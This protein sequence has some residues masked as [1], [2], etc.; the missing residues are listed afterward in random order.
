MRRFTRGNAIVAA[1]TLVWAGAA[2]PAHA[3]PSAPAP[4]PTGATSGAGYVQPDVPRALD[5]GLL[6]ATGDTRFRRAKARLATPATD[7]AGRTFVYVEGKSF[8]AAKAAVTAVNGKVL[9]SNGKRV[10]AAVPGSALVRL[11]RRPGVAQ[12]RQPDK[13]F[14]LAVTS[15]GV[16]ASGAGAWVRAGDGGAGVKIGVIDVGFD[17][18]TDAQTAGEVPNDAALHSVDCP[19]ENASPHGTAVAEVVHDMAPGASLYLACAPDSMTFASA[20]GW[21][22]QQGVQII[23]A[24]I[25]FPN[26]GRGDGSGPAGSPAAVVQQSR[27]AGVLWVAAAGNQAQLHWTGTAADA[28]A[29]GYVE[30]NGTAESNGFT[31]PAGGTATVSLKWDGWPTT[32]KDLDLVVMSNNRQPTGPGDAAIVAQSTNAQADAAQPLAPTEQVTIDNKSGGAQTYWIYTAARASYPDTRADLYVMGDATSLSYPVAAGSVLEPASS[33]YAM[34]VGASL[35]GSGRVDDYS[36]QGPTVDGRT[37]PDIVGQSGVSSMTFGPAPTFA[38]TSVGAAHVTGAAALLKG[39]N[40]QLDPG[41]IQALLEERTKPAK[42]DNQWGHGLL[43]M[44]APGAAQA[45]ATSGYTPLQLPRRLLDT[46]TTLGGHNTPLAAGEVFTLPVAD[47][48][49]D[50]TAVAVNVTGSSANRTHIDL[51][52]D[53]DSYSGVSTVELAANETRTA[54]AIVPLSVARTIAIRNDAGAANAN[55]DLLGYFS[56]ASSGTYTPKDAPQRILDTRGTVGGHNAAFGAGEQFTLPVRGVAGVPETATAVLVNITVTEASAATNLS[57]YPQ[58]QPGQ[59]GTLETD[60]NRVRSNLA[61]TGIGDDGG[62]RIRNQS[63]T[64]QVSVDLVGWFAAGSGARYVPLRF[65]TKILDTRTGTGGQLGPVAQGGTASV[66]VSDVAGVPHSVT[67]PVLAVTGQSD[68]ATSLSLGPAERGWSGLA[69]IAGIDSG[70]TVAGASVP[71]SGG[72]GKVKIRN[73]AGGTQVVVAVTGYF[74]GGPALQAQTGSCAIDAEAGFT[75]MYDGRSPQS[76]QWRLVGAGTVTDANCETS[77]TTTG[78]LRWYPTEHLPAQYTLRLD[79]KATSNTADSGVLLGFANPADDPKAP[80]TTGVE[81]QISPGGAATLA[82]GAI[83]SLK[84]P[85]AQAAKAPGTWNSYEIQ[86]SGKRITVLLNDTVVNDYVVPNTRLLDPGFIG[87]QSNPDGADVTY[88]NIRVRVDAPAARYGPIVGYEGMCVDVVGAQKVQGTQ[89]QTATCTGGD[90]QQF[91]LPGDGTLRI[92]GMC[93]DMNG[94]ARSS[95]TQY[96]V[97][98]TC[99]GTSNQQ[100]VLQPNGTLY[101]PRLNTCLDVPGTTPLYTGPCHG[102]ANQ[103]WAVPAAQARFGPVIGYQGMCVDVVDQSTAKGAQLQTAAC[104]KLG[105][106]QVTMPGDGTLRIYGMCVDMNG[107]ARS[108]TTQ[109]VVLWTCNGT[110]NQ[111]YSLRSNGTLYAPHL[112][113]CLDT[114]GTTPLY[115]GPCHGLANQQWAVPALAPDGTVVAA[116]AARLVASWSAD[117]N[118]G[119]TLADATGNGRPATLKGGYTWTTGHSGS[120]V[121]FDG[122]TGEANAAPS[123]LQTDRSY[124]VAAWVKVT[125]PT[126]FPNAVGEDDAQRSAFFL[127]ASGDPVQWEFVVSTNPATSDHIR[128]GSGSLTTDRWT[129]LVGVYDQAAGQARLYVDGELKGT[130]AVPKLW[131]ATGATTIG[132]GRW[133]NANVNFWTGGIDDV[134]LYQGTLTQAQITALA[135]A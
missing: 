100:Y 73:D 15:E 96:V 46:T 106:Q 16:E 81:V 31:V 65:A 4:T 32:R 26:T 6:A 124:S 42:F 3:D 110:S 20:V 63:G 17:G 93:V 37:K 114:P 126:T 71:R 84:A 61:L 5:V 72:S 92:Y 33:P 101:T 82:T 9:Q 121:S 56:P 69:G 74:A 57:V 132:R 23:N 102:R 98:W 116:P 13:A 35:V 7:K 90:G 27:E 107:P 44:G 130:Q 48:P 120:A 77:A 1:V 88:R 75:P 122:T 67:A 91:T 55:V 38:G 127:R 78:S 8:A 83:S 125:S 99:N 28:D 97:L 19:A 86:V 70:A 25:G 43:A 34:A 10:R 135:H 128:A 112:N 79:W 103:Q 2:G 14:P 123:A 89:L 95:T 80:G 109:Y 30:V 118:S 60:V 11:A 131:N 134:K 29:D 39:A 129:H 54:M 68:G 49:G 47:L 59:F 21:L 87:I 50:A 36:S 119:A 24:A 53:V 40:T 62:I 18:L 41:Q 113:T 76:K 94:P 104:N 58:V 64:A 12:V 66:S 51:F 45:P 133:N 85:V 111:Q 108:S 105:S 115:T 117:E 22:T 52:R